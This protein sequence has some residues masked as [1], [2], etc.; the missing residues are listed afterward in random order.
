M[1][2]V[3]GRGRPGTPTFEGMSDMI[4]PAVDGGGTGPASHRAPFGNAIFGIAPFGI[5][6]FGIAACGNTACGN[7]AYGNAAFGLPRR[8]FTP[9]A[10]AADATGAVFSEVPGFAGGTTRHRG[11]EA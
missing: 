7:T 1:P 3:H 5:A 4:V 2:I 8:A 9:Y 11:Q 6:P 10:A